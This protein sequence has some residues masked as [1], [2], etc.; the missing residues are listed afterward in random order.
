[1]GLL[2]EYIEQAK[3]KTRGYSDIEKLR[4]VYIDLGKKFQFDINFSFGNAKQRMQIYSGGISNE[5]LEKNMETKTII[6]KSL[7]YIFEYIMKELEVNITTVVDE[8]DRRKCKHMY[9][10]LETKENKRYKF[11]LQEDMRFIKARMRTRHFGVAMQEKADN[12]V[13]RQTLGEIDK[14]IGYISDEKYYT[15]EYLEILKLGMNLHDSLTSKMKFLLEN[16]EEYTDPNMKYADRRWRMEDLIG[17][18]NMQGL[19]FSN[20]EKNKINIVDCYQ[21]INGERK[22]ILCITVEEKGKIVIFM[23]DENANS[24]KKLTLEEFAEYVKNGLTNMQGIL[25]LKQALKSKKREERE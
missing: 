5:A 14:K 10:V 18:S 23:F 21:D 22:Y 6:C 8:Y 3:E 15:D 25:G 16:L 7:S 17:N 2:N 1:M 4:E 20:E 13:S 19:L 11:D 24:F 9:N 12:L